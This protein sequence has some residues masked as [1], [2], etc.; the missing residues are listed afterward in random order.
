MRRQLVL[1]F[2][3]KN[4]LAMKYPLKTILLSASLLCLAS[5]CIKEDL[6]ECNPGVLLKYDYSLNPEHSNLFGEEVGKVTV[7]VFDENG[8]YYDRFSEAG[9]HLTND[10]QMRLPLP[11]GNYTTVTWGGALGT[12]RIGE[13]NADETAFQSELKKGVT[14]IDN[15]MLT[16][17]KDGQPL[18]QLDDLY[19]G[20]A[21]VTSVYQPETATT[22]DLMKNTKHLTVTV[23]D[24]TVGRDRTGTDDTPYEVYCTGTNARYLADN[25]FGMKAETITNRPYDTYTI[26]GKAISELDLLRLVIG[27][28]FRLVVNDREG[29]KVF[30]K[31]LVEAMM[32]TGNF[33]TQ[34]DFDR[35]L[36]YNVVITMDKNVVVTITI[37]GWVV[38]DI[39]PDL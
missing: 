29:K 28:P 11:P 33:K 16:A 8:L 4:E 24:Q 19:H 27:R 17:E 22:V 13:T 20:K 38:V 7:F 35:E 12:Y 31:D 26:P 6:S 10:W 30:D 5:G 25:S 2:V 18:A 14:H 23:E 15:F 1:I 9:S 32:A 3:P 36:D 37:N 21:D 34:E 39:E